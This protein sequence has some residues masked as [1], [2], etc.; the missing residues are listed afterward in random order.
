MT[1][2][3]LN[4]AR[5]HGLNLTDLQI[6]LILA[7]QGPQDLTSLAAETGLNNAAITL[8][9]KKLVGKLW[10]ATQFAA[11]HLAKL[12]VKPGTAKDDTAITEMLDQWIISRLG[13]T[14]A[15]ST[16]AFAR[17]EYADALD[18]TNSFFWADF[19]D[20]YLELIKKRVY[21]EDGSFTATQQQS[22]VHAL[23]HCLLGILKLYAPFTPHVT[24]ELYSH[25]FADEYAAKGSLHGRFQWPS[26]NDYYVKDGALAAGIHA[27][28]AL[29]VI[30]KAKSESQRSIKFPITD[31]QLYAATDE[32]AVLAD[33]FLADVAGAG[34]V[35]A[36]TLVR[37]EEAGMVATLSGQLALGITFAAEADAA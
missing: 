21:N 19:C 7:E 23:Y 24:E 13:Q 9:A 1:S 8:A 17:Y 36:A 16:D 31:L 34:N 14:V 35:Q 26:A 6:L 22:A 28:E 15:K 33:A 10:N 18:A 3:A 12:E 30:R 29:E 11:I 5:Y 25:I 20:N 27:L 37:K 32:I 2:T 4:T